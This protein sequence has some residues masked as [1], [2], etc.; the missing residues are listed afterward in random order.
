MI[1]IPKNVLPDIL[2]AIDNTS[3]KLLFENS[4]ER[5]YFEKILHTMNDMIVIGVEKGHL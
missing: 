4:K 1:K 5:F 3:S 2:F